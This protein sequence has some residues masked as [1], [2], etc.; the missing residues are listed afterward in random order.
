VGTDKQAALLG[1][2]EESTDVSRCDRLGF[3]GPD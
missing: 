1:P 3:R 2:G